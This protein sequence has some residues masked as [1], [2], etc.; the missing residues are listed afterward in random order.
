MRK[1]LSPKV[2]SDPIYG[3]IDIKPVLPMVEAREFQSL[4]YKYQLGL[5][6]LVF[7]SATHT[8]RAHSFGAYHTTSQLTEHWMKLGSINEQEAHA[9]QGYALYHDIGHTPFSHVTEPF[10]LID[11][12]LPGLSVHT[13]R[14]FSIIKKLRSAIEACGIDYQLFEDIAR[15]KNPLCLAVS[16]R[17]LGMEKLDYLERD[18]MYTIISRPPGVNYLREHIYFIDN[19]L[20]VDEKV[21]DNARDVQDFYVKM[22]K[23]VYL[24]KACVIAQRMMHKMIYCLMRSDELSAEELTES[25]DFELLG[26]LSVSKN[27]LVN[28]L[29]DLLMRRHLFRETI[30]LRDEK[31]IHAAQTAHKHIALFGV[32]PETMEVI[33]HTNA[34]HIKTPQHIA[35]LEDEIAKIAAIPS[36]AVLVVPVSSPERFQAQDITVY[37]NRG[38]FESMKERYPGH[39]KDMEETARAYT[40]LRVCTLEDYREKLSSAIVAQKVFDLILEKIKA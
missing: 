9:L 6:Y 31:F 32:S 15:H 30:V 17:N 8:R 38:T 11:E 19:K 24:R 28:F 14:S 22:Y 27:T 18:G 5:T 4:T 33:A 10:C 36:N 26:R 40:A 34:S 35:L 21:V 2:I 3:I 7:P 1:I 20:V 16:D 23:N 29:Y 25:N 39:F 13:A 37:T 12:E